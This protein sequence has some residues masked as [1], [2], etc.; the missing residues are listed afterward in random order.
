VD[1]VEVYEA[2]VPSIVALIAR[3][4]MRVPGEQREPL[5]P[6]ILG[7]GFLVNDTGLVA[8]NRHVAEAMQATTPH[9]I[10]GDPG[11]GAV[12]FDM[13]KEPDGAHCMRW[14]LLDVASV[15]MM[16]QFSSNSDWY[17]EAIPDIA[18]VQLEIR[19]TPF[20]KLAKD[21]FYIRPGMPIATA[22]FP[23]GNLPLTVMQK[24][25]Q[26]SPFIR[27]GIVSSVYPFSIPHPHG[28][29]IDIM[30]Q[31]GSSGSPIFYENEPTV[32]GMMAAGMLERA[33]VPIENGLLTAHVPTN[34]SIAVSAHMIGL[35]LPTFLESEF[36]VDT[37]GF[38]TVKE[39]QQTRQASDAL[40][41]DTFPPRAL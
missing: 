31:G 24:V 25:N 20:L 30:Q 19:G 41:W 7:T 27:R 34:I 2:V 3:M 11:Y 13:S 22:G 5:M 36:A 35:A 37:A 23:M 17:G 21:D 14:M 9:P 1:L 26:A 8:T 18:F 32:V 39:W 6:T 29:T 4:V 28:L 12:M 38:S 40:G 10:T 15:G 16:Y 33:P